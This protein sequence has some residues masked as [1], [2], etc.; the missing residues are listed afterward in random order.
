MLARQAAVRHSFSSSPQQSRAL[1]AR[2][3]KTAVTKLASDDEEEDWSDVSE[4]EEVD[5][6]QF[7]SSKD[8]NGNVQN[9]TFGKGKLYNPDL[10]IIVDVSC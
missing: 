1:D 7:Q 4:L 10:R 6:R 8:Q 3:T 9:R 2:V 5:S